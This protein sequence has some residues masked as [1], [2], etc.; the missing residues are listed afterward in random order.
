MPDDKFVGTLKQGARDLVEGSPFV[1]V[2]TKIIAPLGEKV[3]NAYRYAKHK[4]TGQDE[5]NAQRATSAKL[6]TAKKGEV[7]R[8]MSSRRR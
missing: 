8:G 3:Q 4:L 6:Q 1:G 7:R 2:G 5:K